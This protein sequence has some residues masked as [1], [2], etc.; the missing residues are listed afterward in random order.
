MPLGSDL[1]AVKSNTSAVS[2]WGG[3]TPHVRKSFPGGRHRDAI[4]CCINPN[5]LLSRHSRHL[6]DSFL[7]FLPLKTLTSELRDYRLEHDP[8]M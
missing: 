2:G 4:A 7:H 5:T 6:G 8:G 3:R 1:R